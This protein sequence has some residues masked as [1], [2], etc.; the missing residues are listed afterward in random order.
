MKNLLNCNGMKFRCRIKD[1]AAE[2]RIF[3]GM[4]D[5]EKMVWLCQN[6]WNGAD[7][8]NKLGYKYSWV[9]LK[10]SLEDLR[11]NGVTDFR[12]VP[13]TEEEIER[14]DD[15]QVGQQLGTGGEYED[16]YLIV[17]FRS[18]ELVVCKGAS[19]GRARGN[20]TCKE[21][22]RAGYRLV[23]EEI[24]QLEPEKPEPEKKKEK[25]KPEAVKKEEKAEP[26]AEMKA[27][28]E[29]IHVPAGQKIT[30]TIEQPGEPDG[31]IRIG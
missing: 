8:P 16:A 20:F 31:H 22:H 5:S 27:C 13:F 2:G 3:V 7:A 21:L 14:Y 11:R 9:V 18:G 30:I 24:E 29:W 17:I 19:T 4:K 6:T 15:F 25:T 1:E 12:L 28:S 26:E 10:G 23:Q